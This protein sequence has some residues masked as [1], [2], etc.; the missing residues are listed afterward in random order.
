[1][2]IAPLPAKQIHRA[3]NNRFTHKT[4]SA[5][6]CLR[7]CWLGAHDLSQPS[8]RVPNLRRWCRLFRHSPWALPHWRGERTAANLAP[9]MWCILSC[10]DRHDMV[11]KP[12]LPQD[13][14]SRRGSEDMD[15]HA[16]FA[17]HA[18]ASLSNVYQ[19]ARC[20]TNTPTACAMLKMEL[21]V[22]SRKTAGGGTCTVQVG[23]KRTAPTG[24]K[25]GVTLIWT[26]LHC[27]I[28]APSSVWNDF[29]RFCCSWRMCFHNSDNVL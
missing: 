21:G 16:C 5:S 24:P 9:L 28:R 3:T 15:V 10:P 1:M 8:Q 17:N 27:K 4:N 23:V 22:I 2:I 19:C 18:L 12:P 29:T 20:K 13:S 7:G 26:V 25:L 11:L 6:A 14:S